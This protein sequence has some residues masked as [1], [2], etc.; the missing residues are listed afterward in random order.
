MR[1]LPDV[2]AGEDRSGSTAICALICPEFIYLANCGDSRGLI[3]AKE[4]IAVATLDHKPVNPLEKERIQNAG[5]SV[6]IQRVNGSLAVSRAL[7]DFEYKRV[8][9]MGPFEQLISPEPEI[10]EHARS[11]Q[12]EFIVLACDGVW[13]VMSNEDVCQFVRYQLTVTDNLERICEGI[14]DNCLNKV[15]SP[16]SSHYPAFS[17]FRLFLL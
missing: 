12:D 1:K 7:G 17:C 8:P 15:R 13:D 10:S 2:V 16:I 9:N 6:M 5:G 14:V 3:S 4:A 11:G